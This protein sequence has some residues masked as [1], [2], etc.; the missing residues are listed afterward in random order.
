MWCLRVD[1]FPGITILSTEH[2]PTIKFNHENN[3]PRPNELI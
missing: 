2:I 3:I 1:T